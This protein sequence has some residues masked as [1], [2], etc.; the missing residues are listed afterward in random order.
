[1]CAALLET[2]AGSYGQLINLERQLP[3]AAASQHEV[4]ENLRSVCLNVEAL[5]IRTKNVNARITVVSG[6]IPEIQYVQVFY[7]SK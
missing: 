4:P 6:H 5:K 2:V 1:M 3:G 7:C